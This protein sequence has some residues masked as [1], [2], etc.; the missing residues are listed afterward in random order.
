M[1]G[2]FCALSVVIT[3]EE[4]CLSISNGGCW[5]GSLNTSRFVRNTKRFAQRR[6]EIAFKTITKPVFSLTQSLLSRIH[7][8][9][10]REDLEGSQGVGYVGVN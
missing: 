7:E 1:I 9:K 10:G 4:R 5:S 2:V 8:A 3:R 6:V